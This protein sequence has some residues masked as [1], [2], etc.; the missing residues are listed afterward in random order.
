MSDQTT[1]VLG[2]LP[3]DVQGE[4]ESLSDDLTFVTR[5]GCNALGIGERDRYEIHRALTE[6]RRQIYL[7]TRRARA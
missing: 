4:L 1:N 5:D 6:L 7:A 3:P 2:L